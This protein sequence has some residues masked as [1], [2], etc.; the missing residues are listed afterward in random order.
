[1]ETILVAIMWAN[2]ET[3]VLQPMAEIAD[4]V[5]EHGMM[6]L[7]VSH[8]PRDALLASPRCAFICD[9]RVAALQPTA[10]LLEANPLPALR[11][12]LGSE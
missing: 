1:M 4:M 3:G 11:A 2:N 12:Y 10:E 6:A 9:G 7:L 8:Q 5:R